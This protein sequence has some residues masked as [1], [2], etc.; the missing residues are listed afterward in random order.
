MRQAVATTRF[1][2]ILDTGYVSPSGWE[3]ACQALL[4]GGAGLIQLRA[5][6]ETPEERHV[7]LERILPLFEKRTTSLIINDDLELALAHP[8]LGLHVGQDDIAIEEARQ[9]LGPDRILGLSTH[10]PDQARDA[11]AR[12][13]LLDYFAV[14]P[15]FATLT[16]P[17]AQPVG[18]ELVATVAK[19]SPPLPWFCIG[20]IKRNNLSAVQAAGGERVVVVSEV[21]QAPDPVALIQRYRDQLS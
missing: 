20:G 9:A 13:D 12:K 3:A 6:Q 14:G 1:Y 10:S 2:A 16:K 4:D 17:D 15:V 18:L 8:R 7:L 11:I 19:M 21:L 5:K